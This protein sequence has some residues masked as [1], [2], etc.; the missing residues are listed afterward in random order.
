MTFNAMDE[1]NNVIREKHW[2]HKQIQAAGCNICPEIVLSHIPLQQIMSLS[3]SDMLLLL[4]LQRG[5][6]FKGFFL[7]AKY[8]S[9]SNGTPEKRPLILI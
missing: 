8:L 6:H 5:L 9:Y 3:L 1:V 4:P 7:E 2:D